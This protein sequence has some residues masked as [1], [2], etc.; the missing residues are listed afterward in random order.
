M[1][2]NNGP[3]C[4]AD[5]S[6][7]LGISAFTTDNQHQTKWLFWIPI[8]FLLEFKATNDRYLSNL[9]LYCLPLW[10]IN[11]SH[12]VLGSMQFKMHISLFLLLNNQICR[13]K[14]ANAKLK[15]KK[16]YNA[17]THSELN[18]ELYS[19]KSVKLFSSAVDALFNISWASF[20]T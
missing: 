6:F 7:A 3:F 1:W 5:A 15:K 12:D 17:P 16:I 19:C 10:H 14:I 4:C 8:R 13:N 9:Q 11:W 20:W 2:E 18:L